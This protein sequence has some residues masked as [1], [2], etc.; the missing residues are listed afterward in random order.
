M[1]KV[2]WKNRSNKWC[3][4]TVESRPDML[5]EVADKLL[6]TDKVKVEIIGD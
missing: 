5:M 2:S 4:I 1:F 6:F 3:F